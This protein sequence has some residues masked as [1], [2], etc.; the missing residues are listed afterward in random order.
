MRSMK[1]A[2]RA[3]FIGFAL[4]A[5]LSLPALT[6]GAFPLEF[7]RTRNPVIQHPRVPPGG[8]YDVNQ[9]TAALF[10]DS[11]SQRFEVTDGTIYFGILSGE[12]RVRKA[13][14]SAPAYGQSGWSAK[15]AAAPEPSALAALAA[16]LSLVTLR[17]SR[18]S[19]K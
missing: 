6:A 3:R 7:G 9:D 11:P 15:G 5:A 18:R 4:I 13:S 10:A 17:R 19:A 14:D 16:A 8:F 1:T 2:R 12:S